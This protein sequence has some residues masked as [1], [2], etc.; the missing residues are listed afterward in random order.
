M[1]ASLYQCEGESPK[2]P[3]LSRLSHLFIPKIPGTSKELEPRA[4]PFILLGTGILLRC[5]T[6]EFVYSR[7]RDRYILVYNTLTKVIM[8]GLLHHISDRIGSSIRVPSPVSRVDIDNTHCS[9]Q[10]L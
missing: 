4:A 10:E 5:R 6:L 1:Q 8:R 2:F 3:S 7:S 9:S